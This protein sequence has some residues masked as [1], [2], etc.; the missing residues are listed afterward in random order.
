ML[1]TMVF[2]GVMFTFFVFTHDDPL[3]MHGY[4]SVF[5]KH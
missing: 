1:F 4:E 2:L 3:V 5:G